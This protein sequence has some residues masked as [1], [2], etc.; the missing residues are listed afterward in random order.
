MR[1]VTTTTY[2]RA[3]R[4]LLS[5]EEREAM[6][7]AILARPMDAS[8]I[9]GSGGI[10]KAR[11]AASGR[12]KRG[13]VRTIYFHLGEM[14]TIYLLTIYAKAEREDLRPADLK[15]WAKLVAAIRKE[16]RR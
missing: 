14:S 12:G 11:W 5:A 8:V 13:H 7:R 6:E 16:A 15:A 2:E 9:P 1:V 10:R 3:A 4:K